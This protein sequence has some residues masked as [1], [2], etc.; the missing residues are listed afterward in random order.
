MQKCSCYFYGM[1][2][3]KQKAIFP[4]VITLIVILPF[5]FIQKE[6]SLLYLNGLHTP[7]LDRFFLNVTWLGEGFFIWCAFLLILFKRVKWF[8]VFLIAVLTH[9]LLIQINK[10]LLFSD[11][12]RPLGHFRAMDAEHL[13]HRIEGL[14]IFKTKSFPSGH[15]TGA[16]FSA[17][18]I[19]LAI[20]NTKV[21]WFLAILSLAVGISRVYLA[22]HFLIDIYFG[23]LFGTVSSVISLV[24]TTRL[25]PKYQWMDDYVSQIIP[26][27]IKGLP[28]SKRWKSD[29]QNTNSIR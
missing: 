24:I 2:I 1:N 23:F 14:R 3:L 10:E 20:K 4:F 5:I 19:A 11:V 7:L 22:Q 27:K 29:P 21:S 17:A 9:V 6:Q 25:E 8:I 26:I 12:L 13:L 18:F 16:A 28:I 15:T